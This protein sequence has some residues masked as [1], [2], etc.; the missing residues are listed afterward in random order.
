MPAGQLIWVLS[1]SIGSRTSS[2]QTSSP[3]AAET[4]A[5]D[6]AETL[7]SSARPPSCPS[8]LSVRAASRRSSRRY[9]TA[10]T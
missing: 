6:E 2:A 10:S 1:E 7:T 3:S 4:T 8:V 9:S 5:S